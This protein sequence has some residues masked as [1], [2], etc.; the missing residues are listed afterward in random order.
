MS[1]TKQFVKLARQGKLPESTVVKMAELKE[2][3]GHIKLSAG[4]GNI[5]TA[6][7]LAAAL[8]TAGALTD[9]ASAAMSNWMENRKREPS[10]NK[11]LEYHPQLKNENMELVRKY[12]D[13]VWHFSPHMAQDPLAAGA[14]IRQA[15]QF[16]DIHGGPPPNMA[17]DLADM[18]KSVFQATPLATPYGSNTTN[19]IKS[20]VEL[21][22][23]GG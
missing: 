4:G 3:L 11:M 18:Q 14:Y 23:L 1:Y 5:T 7:A 16:N 22:G 13:S 19:N 15:L 10:F 17:K 12:F 6:L 8:G 21:L 20:T 2:R 9:N